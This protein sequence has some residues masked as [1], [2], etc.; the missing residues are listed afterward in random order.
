MGRI[1]VSVFVIV[2]V[3]LVIEPT[4]DECVQICAVVCFEY[5]AVPDRG[6]DS[7]R[8]SQ[9]VDVVLSLPL[10][11]IAVDFFEECNG[12][13]RYLRAVLR[14]VPEHLRVACS[15]DV[16]DLLANFFMLAVSFECEYFLDC[17]CIDELYLTLSTLTGRASCGKDLVWRNRWRQSKGGSN[18]DKLAIRAAQL[19]VSN[20]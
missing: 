16:Y 20:R 1:E 11:L 18:Q 19:G 6:V 13:E 3:V 5:E 2:T 10:P 17:A 9:L 4:A 15:C 8:S 14:G 12:V 7:I